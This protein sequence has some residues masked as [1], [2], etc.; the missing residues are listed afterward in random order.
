VKHQRR[1]DKSA[2]KGVCQIHRR[3][4]KPVPSFKLSSIGTNS[5]PLSSVF[6]SRKAFVKN[7]ATGVAVIAGL[8]PRRKGEI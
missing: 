2:A 6:G 7:T 3:T 5:P 4:S 8:D 1:E